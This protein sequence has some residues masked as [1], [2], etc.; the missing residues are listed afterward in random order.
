MNLPDLASRAAELASQ[1]LPVF[2]C[3]ADKA[4]CTTHGFKDAISDPGKAYALF[5]AHPGA[6]LVAIATGLASGFTVVDVDPDGFPWMFRN[7]HRLEPTQINQSRR[8]YHLIYRTPDPPVRNSASVLARGV[9]IRGEG[10][11]CVWWPAVGEPIRSLGPPA[12]FPRWIIQA[13]ARIAKKRLQ[14]TSGDI[15]SSGD[16]GGLER[17]VSRLTPGTRNHGLFWAAARAGEAGIAGAETALIHAAMV[18]GLNAIEAR[19][20]VRSGMARG[21]RDGKRE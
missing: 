4:P 15:G 20:T 14:A 21:A 6:R 13:L 12:P 17:F 7:L 3:R 9:D 8:G 10:G 18:S 1:G 19:S 5:M 2:P 11:C 16:I